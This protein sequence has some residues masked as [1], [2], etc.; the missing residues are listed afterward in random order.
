MQYVK[1]VICPNTHDKQ[2]QKEKY[3]DVIFWDPE[4]GETS[5]INVATLKMWLILDSYYQFLESF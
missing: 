2:E 5:C 1:L 3:P 4:V